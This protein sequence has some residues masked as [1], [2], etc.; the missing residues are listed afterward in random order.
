MKQVLLLFALIPALA[1][2]SW[3]FTEEYAKKPLDLPAGGVA[4]EE[5]DEDAPETISFYG[6]EYEG[7]AFFWC[8]AA[9]EF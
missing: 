3:A 4:D 5:E 1:I 9:Y 2:T 8:F 6:G 7:D